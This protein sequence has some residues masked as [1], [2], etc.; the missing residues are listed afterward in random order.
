MRPDLFAFSMP[1]SQD[2]NE[3]PLD[4]EED[5]VKMRIVAIK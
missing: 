3:V 4:S 5:P 1:D 2:I